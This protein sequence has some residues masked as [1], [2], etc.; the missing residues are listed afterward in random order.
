[1]TVSIDRQDVYADK[2]EHLLPH[3]RIAM[4]DVDRVLM[5]LSLTVAAGT[6]AVQALRYAH[7]SP[8]AMQ[9]SCFLCV[10][11]SDSLRSAPCSS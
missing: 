4:S 10:R 5:G 7:H 8:I 3:T 11:L 2:L 6:T 9:A 1:M